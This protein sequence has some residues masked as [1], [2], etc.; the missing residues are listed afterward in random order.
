VR[1]YW[2]V[3]AKR[4]KERIT[5]P[6]PPAPRASFEIVPDDVAQRLRKIHGNLPL[7]VAYAR[8]G[9]LHDAQDAMNSVVQANP[10]SALAKQLR[11]SLLVK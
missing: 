10:D 4:G 2:Q 6:A 8:E 9:M 5:A 1:L 11:D 7:A 3:T